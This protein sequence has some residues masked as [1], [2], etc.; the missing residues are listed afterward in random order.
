MPDF[1]IK[2]VSRKKAISPAFDMNKKEFMQGV[3]LKIE[4]EHN[5]AGGESPGKKLF[6]HS[7]GM[8]LGTHG[9]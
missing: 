6:P 1:Q 2:K 9:P 4:S 8:A 3:S 7:Y 5:P